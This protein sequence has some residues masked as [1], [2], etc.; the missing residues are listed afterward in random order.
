MRFMYNIKQKVDMKQIQLVPGC[1][2]EV[3]LS[4]LGC[5]ILFY[6]SVAGGRVK[7]GP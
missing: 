6:V 4:L 3:S 1:V 2:F 5:Y 7:R